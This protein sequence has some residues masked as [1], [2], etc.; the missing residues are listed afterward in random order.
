MQREDPA[1]CGS[2]DS[3]KYTRQKESVLK[4]HK[5]AGNTLY[6]YTLGSPDAEANL[7][8]TLIRKLVEGRHYSYGDIA[9]FYRT[10]QLAETLVDRLHQ[11][12]IGFQRVGRINSFQE[13]H[14]QGIISYLNFIQ[15]QLPSRH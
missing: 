5:D 6:H 2:G 3:Q 14:A 13:E 9:V 10:H 12:R 4:T 7:V 8:I 1:L 15:W 11:E